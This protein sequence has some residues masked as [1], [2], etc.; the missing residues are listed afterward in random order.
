MTLAIS[1][2][3]KTRCQ[4]I[5]PKMPR[6][7]GMFELQQAPSSVVK[8]REPT[9]SFLFLCEHGS[10]RTYMQ[11]SYAVVADEH[12]LVTNLQTWPPSRVTMASR[13]KPPD[14]NPNMTPIV[15]QLL[16][17]GNAAPPHS[18]N[19]LSADDSAIKLGRQVSPIS[20]PN[21]KY[22]CR[23]AGLTFEG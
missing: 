19:K 8:R 5:N 17:K 13:T 20:C 18:C 10:T 16:H 23:S 12:P 6:T 11:T 4:A 2:G 15:R 3:T 14:P 9:L 21:T 22:S 1:N 7:R